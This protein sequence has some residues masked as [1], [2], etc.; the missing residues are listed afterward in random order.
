MKTSD[1][2]SKK[3]DC[4]GCE[5]CSYACPRKV[6]TMEPD[7]EG[8]F[9][10]V[11]KDDSNCINCAR[12]LKVCPSK[13]SVHPSRELLESYGG[14]CKD[15]DEIKNSSSGG[16]A[17]SLGREFIR[18][19]GVVYGVRYSS[20]FA[21]VVYDRADNETALE[22]FRTSKYVQSR[23]RDIYGRVLNDLKNGNRVLFTGLPCE[24]SAL[25]HYVGPFDKNLYTVSLI[26]HGPTSPKVHQSFCE[27]LK[28]TY[29]SEISSFSVRHK[30]LG[31]KP[32]YI[33]A[34]FASGECHQELYSKSDYG[35]AFLYMKRPSC[36]VCRYKW[37]NKEFGL[38]ADMTL[39]DFHAVKKE[40]P[41]YN[42]WGSS[43]ACIQSDKGYELLKLI[44]KSCLAEIIPAEK[45]RS[46]NI[47][48]VSPIPAN[49]LRSSFVS[50]F[51]NHSLSYA[52]HIPSIRLQRVLKSY[53]EKLI[54]F[55]VLTRK[56]LLR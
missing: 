3:K 46:G 40:M 14:F 52:A 48:F 55:A 53:K 4:C 23:K 17:T 31:W 2:Y 49:R 8:F 30:L 47:A 32:Y 10:P 21:E 26:C 41:H 13:S 42:S 28:A 6:I 18:R 27:N 39:G 11:I 51:K 54:R 34:N 20:D 25:Y 45:I 15:V 37:G 5:L 19:G 12:C 33:S 35:I 29:N 43:Q 38:V 36:S 22:S 7:E 24:I 9:Y 44:Q 50:A 16:F 56:F 1:L